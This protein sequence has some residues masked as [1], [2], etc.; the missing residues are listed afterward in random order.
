MH[1]TEDV[2]R[3]VPIPRSRMFSTV[4]AFLADHG[5]AVG[6]RRPQAVGC[7]QTGLAESAAALD[8]HADE[9]HSIDG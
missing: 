2:R 3:Y 9:V 5:L 4:I 6:Y 7:A 8:A 1:Q